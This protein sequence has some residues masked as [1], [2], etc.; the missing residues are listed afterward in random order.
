MDRQAGHTRE[1]LQV[2]QGTSAILG[3]THQEAEGDRGCQTCDSLG[4]SIQGL[5]TGGTVTGYKGDLQCEETEVQRAS[6]ILQTSDY[7]GGG[8][9]ATCVQASWLH[10]LLGPEE[11]Q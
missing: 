4:V 9:G 1:V 7:V 6:V 8:G 2:P 3:S 10:P 5:G 11:K